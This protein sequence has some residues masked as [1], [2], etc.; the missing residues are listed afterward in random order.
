M[1]GTIEEANPRERHRSRII[2]FA[3]VALF[4][5][6]LA[7]ALAGLLG[8]GPLSRRSARSADGRINVEHQRYV[9][10]QAPVDL[11]IYIAPDA[12]SNGLVELRISRNFVEKAEIRRIDPEPESIAAGPKY[13]THIIRV[14]TNAATQ[15]KV[16]FEPGHMGSLA[17]EVGVD[18]G[19]PIQLRH[20][21]FP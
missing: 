17:Y 20:F 10:Y 18:H 9:R 15:V 5:A 4:L 1:A 8:Q 16:R 19:R 6:A 7:A 14:E 13:F 2:H 3:G 11:R 21:A 12:T